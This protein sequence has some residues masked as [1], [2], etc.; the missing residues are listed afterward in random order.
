M[1]V[2]EYEKTPMKNDSN[3]CQCFLPVEIKFEL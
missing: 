1:I 3:G 2:S